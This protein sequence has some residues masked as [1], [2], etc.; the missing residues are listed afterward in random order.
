MPP[1]SA[2]CPETHRR[3]EHAPV[4][5]EQRWPVP[6]APISII[7]RSCHFN[8]IMLRAATSASSCPNPGTWDPTPEPS[9]H[10]ERPGLSG[11]ERAGKQPVQKKVQEIRHL[12]SN[13]GWLIM[14]G[15]GSPRKPT[16]TGPGPGPQRLT[17][18]AKPQR[19]H[20]ICRR[21]PAFTAPLFPI[22]GRRGRH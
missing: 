14:P 3:L 4:H 20:E 21:H 8:I 13:R 18:P 5:T 12:P 11:M 7:R 1:R 19:H 6:S 10:R 15:R 16:I 22:L 17:R 9:G 2:V